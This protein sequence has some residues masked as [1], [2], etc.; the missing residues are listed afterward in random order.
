VFC[1]ERIEDFPDV[2]DDGTGACHPE[3]PVLKD[4]IVLHIDN[5][6]CGSLHMAFL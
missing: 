6:Q 1:P 4:E 5:Q 3:G 2:R